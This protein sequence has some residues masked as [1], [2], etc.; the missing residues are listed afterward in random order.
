MRA[1]NRDDL[2]A[3]LIHRIPALRAAQE[4]VNRAPPA[5][6]AKRIKAHRQLWAD[7]RP[8][9]AELSDNK[10]WYVECRSDGADD[11][12]DHFRPKGGVAEERDRSHPGYYWLAFEWSNFR[13][14]CHRANRPRKAP[15]T[16]I[17]GGKGEHFPLIDP[18][19][20]AFGPGDRYEDEE[21]ALLDPLNSADVSMLSFRTTGEVALAPKWKDN[22]V[23]QRKLAMSRL[24][25]HLDWNTF[26]R[27]RAR[28]YARV[29]GLVERGARHAP[30]SLAAYTSGSS[31]FLDVVAE[32]QSLLDPK[33][34][35]ARAARCY[36]RIYRTV[37]W[38]RDIVLDTPESTNE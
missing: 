4:E 1:I 9:L 16:G 11:D 36:V 20:R 33:A 26:Q 12:V 35:Y 18:S 5:E 32:L 6:R 19:K 7:L 34:E 14:S 13:L 25:L 15:K 28:L 38:V 29:D 3:K 22:E 21:P 24:Y 37:W 31:D 27:A 10:C 17:T 2:R 23:A 8:H 30:P